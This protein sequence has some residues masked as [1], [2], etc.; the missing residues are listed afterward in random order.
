MAEELTAEAIYD[1][2]LA[3]MRLR[4]VDG[5][6]FGRLSDSTHSATELA[7]FELED[8]NPS[9]PASDFDPRNNV[10]VLSTTLGWWYS[11]VPIPDEPPE[12]WPIVWN[13]PSG[14]DNT[15]LHAMDVEDLVHTE[16]ALNACPFASDIDVREEA[17]TLIGIYERAFGIDAKRALAL[18]DAES[19]G[20]EIADP[21]PDPISEEDAEAFMSLLII[22]DL[23]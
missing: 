3:L 10:L 23:G 13:E 8:D 14:D 1:D 9:G 11:I 12:Y 5:G 17:F 4:Q 6:A 21:R 20:E 18:W 7:F 19:R 22:P 15:F 16:L 2:H